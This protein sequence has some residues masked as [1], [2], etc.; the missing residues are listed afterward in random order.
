MSQKIIK[1]GG[2]EPNEFEKQV[3]Q[4]L[5]NLEVSDYYTIVFNI[6]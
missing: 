1:A 4:E 6:N 2:V 5:V 3:A